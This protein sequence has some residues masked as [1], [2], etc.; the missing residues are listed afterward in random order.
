MSNILA[1]EDLAKYYSIGGGIMDRLLGKPGAVVRAVDGISF[2]IA[3]GET[4]GLVGESGCGKSTVGRSILRLL[5]PTRGTISLRGQNISHLSRRALRPLRQHMQ[6]VF[7]DPFASLN[8]RRTVGQSVAE[9]ILNFGLAKGNRLRS[10]VED[11]FKHVGLRPDQVDR[12]PHEFSGGQRQRIG[13]ARTLGTRP[14]LIVLD[15]PVSALDVSVQAQVINLLCDL[16]QEFGLA[17]LFIAHDLAVV[18]HIS[19]RVA[20]MYLGKI[21]E[22]ADK[23]SLFETP[24]HPYT[25]ALLSAVPS[26]D[27]DADNTRIVLQGDIPSPTNPPSGCRFR[28][29]CPVAQSICSDEEPALR[30]QASNHEAACHFAGPGSLK[31]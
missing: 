11:L 5:E 30:K 13:I 14:K 24:R 18:E 9:P 10:E 23:K 31:T 7:Q 1:V 6:V 19:S 27:P 8:P 22:I 12:Y 21:V 28:S 26:L 3:A 15:E 16:Q 4:L 20:V 17:Y 29:R 25:K 2:D